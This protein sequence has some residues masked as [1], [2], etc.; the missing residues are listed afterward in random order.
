MKIVSSKK[1][2]QM[3]VCYFVADTLALE[4][5]SC[6]H[7]P[8]TWCYPMPQNFVAIQSTRYDLKNII[9]N[10]Y[11]HSTYDLKNIVRQ[12]IWTSMGARRCTNVSGRKGPDGQNWTEMWRTSDKTRINAPLSSL[13]DSTVSPK[14]KIV[15]G[16]WVR[17]HS[18]ARSTS[19][20]EGRA[21]APGWD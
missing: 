13:M 8:K 14:V 12:Q 10:T 16:E 20:V 17:A 2:V 19:R 15:E 1:S 3:I 7:H 21:R 11:V 4:E 18:M 9:S 6:S 5:R